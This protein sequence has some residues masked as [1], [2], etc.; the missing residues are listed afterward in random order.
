M[1]I[2]IHAAD[3]EQSKQGRRNNSSHSLKI[4]KDPGEIML[5]PKHYLTTVCV[6]EKV[7]LQTHT[8]K[9]TVIMATL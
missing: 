1:S 9:L 6:T 2:F 4:F 8:H 3:S 5:R 7:D